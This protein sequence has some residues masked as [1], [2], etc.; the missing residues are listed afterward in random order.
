M[1]FEPEITEF[2]C[3]NCANLFA[4]TRE[5]ILICPECGNAIDRTA[6]EKLL[7]YAADA[8]EYGYHY[9]QIYEEDLKQGDIEGANAI[10]FDDIW[11]F[12]ALAGLSGVIGNATY[13]AIRLA[14]RKISERRLALKDDQLAIEAVKDV[15]KLI[16][17]EQDFA[18]F[19]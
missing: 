1:R 11:M 10:V 2:I 16:D 6:H 17:N 15:L 8:V 18:L 3:F 4:D 7:E 19:L 5:V 12:V 14:I 13:D 9:R